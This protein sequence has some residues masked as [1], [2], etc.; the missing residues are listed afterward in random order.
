MAAPALVATKTQERFAPPVRTL[1]EIQPKL[2]TEDILRNWKPKT[3]GIIQ[4]IK[5]AKGP[6]IET[7]DADMALDLLTL[8]I[9]H[10]RKLTWS[11]IYRWVE[12]MKSPQ[13]GQYNGD[14]IRITTEMKLIDG[15]NRLWAVYISK[16]PYITIIAPNIDPAVIS[17]IDLGENRTAAHIAAINGFGGNGIQLA[18]AVKN[19]LLYKR[20]GVM[21]GGVSEKEVPN[22]D[23]NI[24]MQNKVEMDRLNHFIG[25]AKTTAMHYNEKF[26]TVPQWATAYYILHSLPGMEKTANTFMEKFASG[27][28]LKATSP[29]KKARTHFELEFK[30]FTQGKQR[31]RLSTPLLTIKF[32]TLFTAWNHYVKQET[33]SDIKF[34]VESRFIVK[35]LFR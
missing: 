34:D 22:Y 14:S 5:S 1:K 33:V 7:I 27:V 25:W 17:T 4:K 21:K 35:P 20:L 19:I 32:N 30:H 8:N 24:F 31:N 18:Y 26:F 10:N 15:Q 11:K 29:I 2:D 28:D 12:Q 3:N 23:V 13:W 16:V 9:D 6:F